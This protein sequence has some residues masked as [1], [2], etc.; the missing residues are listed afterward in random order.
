MAKPEDKTSSGLR[1]SGYGPRIKQAV[2]VVILLVAIVAAIALSAIWSNRQQPEVGV[3]PTPRPTPTLSTPEPTE[4]IPKSTEPTEVQVPDT[5]T[6]SPPETPIKNTPTLKPENTAMPATDRST[7]TLSPTATE[8]PAAKIVQTAEATY[9][10]TAPT[11]PTYTPDV[12]PDTPTVEP[13]A[14]ATHTPAPKPTATPNLAPTPSPTAT[15][16]VTPTPSVPTMLE[17][18]A[19]GQLIDRDID[20]SDIKV[21]SAEK[22]TWLDLT[23]GCGP[24]D[25][26]NPARHVDGWILVLGNEEKT[27]TFHVA[28]KDQEVHEDLE[29]KDDIIADCADVENSEQRIVNLVHDLRLHEAHRVVLYRGPSDGEQAPVQDIQDGA[30]ILVI[31][32]ALNTDTPI[33]NTAICKTAFR[34]DF[35]LFRGI[36]S[37]HFFCQNDWYRGGGEQEVW[38]GTQGALTQELLDAVAPY[39]AAEPLPGLPTWTPGE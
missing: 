37:I 3:Q 38:D 8:V 18:K 15:P 26:D 39:L 10:P 28:S 2:I 5:A 20:Q 1:V 30:R 24:I 23:L 32:D 4:P 16:T 13:T 22:R 35:Y 7:A 27:Y 21:L 25:G 11:A 14:T 9:T 36:Q 19:R 31:L 6:P 33:G 17:I 29:V 34:L 12:P